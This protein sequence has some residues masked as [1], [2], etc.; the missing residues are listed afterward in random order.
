M[1]VSMVLTSTIPL[2]S[3]SNCWNVCQNNPIN[4]NYKMW[5]NVTNHVIWVRFDVFNW[6]LNA[7]FIYIPSTSTSL[8]IC[9]PTIFMCK[10]IPQILQE[11]CSR[12][13]FIMNQSIII[14]FIIIYGTSLS[15]GM[16][17]MSPGSVLTLAASSRE[18]PLFWSQ[19]QNLE[20]VSVSLNSSSMWLPKAVTEFIECNEQPTQKTKT[21]HN[22][23]NFIS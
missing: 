9:W 7:F 16:T 15:S 12:K 10:K 8:F 23:G 22:T 6:S 20:M 13:C 17:Y 5:K 18:T 21:S 14:E 11:S 4:A 19:S 3:V 1:I 2:P